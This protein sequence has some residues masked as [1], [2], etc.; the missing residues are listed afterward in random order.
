MGLSSISTPN[1][2]AFPFIQHSSC[3]S[4]YS[5]SV[6]SGLVFFFHHSLSREHFLNLKSAAGIL[7]ACAPFV[8]P[9]LWNLSLSL[10][11]TISQRFPVPSIFFSLQSCAHGWDPSS[12][13]VGL[14]KGVK[15]LLTR[16]VFSSAA[17]FH[18][19]L[20]FYL[21]DWR[22]FFMAIFKVSN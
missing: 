6:S 12:C 2:Q 5:S 7:S 15:R 20:S 16:Y 22:P 1:I 4:F 9:V 19:Q 17:F 14:D 10:F 11:W 21:F 13:P 18:H 3:P 8:G